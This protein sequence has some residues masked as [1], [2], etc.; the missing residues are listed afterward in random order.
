MKPRRAFAA[1]LRSLSI[2]IF[3]TVSP[4]V[5]GASVAADYQLQDSYGSSVGG[6]GALVPIGTTTDL[7]F[8]SD[9]VGGRTQEVLTISTFGSNHGVQA[10]TT[11]FVNPADYSVVLL[12]SY[13]LAGSSVAT[14]IFD[15]KNL[16]SDAGLYINGATGL[17]SF[18]GVLPVPPIGGTVV[19]GGIYNQIVLTRDGSTGLTSIYQDGALAFSFTDTN[20]D[21]IL[22]DATAT[23]NGYLSVFDDDNANPVGVTNESTQGNLARLRLYDGALTSAE[24]A[25]LDT[26]VVPEAG[27]VVLGALGMLLF[28]HRRRR[29]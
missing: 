28:L 24:V 9:V 2:F 1:H 3:T 19:L 15:F 10:A 14:K 17:I 11:G 23:G 13:N 20:G 26:I 21:A 18:N 25:A 29:G 12:A 8:T 5:F 22:G 6:I 4:G 7:A 16:S 27:S